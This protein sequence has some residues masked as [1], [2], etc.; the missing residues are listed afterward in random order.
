M[1]IWNYRQNANASTVPSSNS[2]GGKKVA[3]FRIEGQNIP[4]LNKPDTCFT[5]CL[6]KGLLMKNWELQN[7]LFNFVAQILPYI[8]T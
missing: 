5:Y 8:Y 2:S 3:F 4:N 6:F 1:W 7:C